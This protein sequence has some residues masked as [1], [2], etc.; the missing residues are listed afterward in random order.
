MT[1]SELL[2]ELKR[3]DVKL[4]AEGG[5]LRVDAPKG[6]LS[7]G[8]IASIRG[9]KARLLE[10]FP[11]HSDPE[12]TIPVRRGERREFPLSLSQHAFFMLAQL[13]PENRA[14][15]IH[16]VRRV[17]GPIDTQ[18][19]A[20]AVQDVVARHETL[21][22]RFELRDG[23]GVQIVEAEVHAP[24]PVVDLSSLPE[25]VRE[26]QA[27]AMAS[28]DRGPGFRIQSAPLF[29]IE[30]IR[31][32][33][34]SHVFVLSMHHIVSD[35]VSLDVFYGDLLQAYEQR[36]RGRSPEFAA[37]PVQY[38]DYSEWQRR[39]MEGPSLAGELEFWRAE[40]SGVPRL[41]DALA[42]VDAPAADR[43]SSIKTALPDDL[44]RRL[45]RF[46]ESHGA[47]LF[48]VL[49]SAFQYLLGRYAR[50]ADVPVIVPFSARTG[51]ETE[52][53]IGLFVNGLVV[54]TY[55]RARTTAAELVAA[56]RKKIADVLSH[57]ELSVES[58][59]GLFRLGGRP[60]PA[61]AR[62]SRIGFNYVV[63]G[64]RGPMQIGGLTVEPVE[65]D[66]T[67]SVFELM[68]T[69]TDSAGELQLRL[70]YK[71]DLFHEGLIEQF[72]GDLVSVLSG[73]ADAPDKILDEIHL[74]HGYEGAVPLPPRA[75]C[76]E[77]LNKGNHR[78]LG[79][80]IDLEYPAS[81]AILSESLAT[82]VAASPILRTR[83]VASPL[84][85]LD[86]EYACV[87]MVCDTALEEIEVH[88][89]LPEAILRETGKLYAER[90]WRHLI[91]RYPDGRRQYVFL[92]NEA[93]LGPRA[94]DAHRNAVVRGLQGSIDPGDSLEIVVDPAAAATEIAALSR[95]AGRAREPRLVSLHKDVDDL[96]AISAWCDANEITLSNFFQCVY[97]LLIQ[98][99]T[100]AD[101]PFSFWLSA[102]EVLEPR[103]FQP[104]AKDASIASGLRTALRRG[105]HIADLPANEID[106]FFEESSFPEIRTMASGRSVCVSL[107]SQ[108]DRASLSLYFD[109]AEFS[110]DLF[111]DR[112]ISVARQIA[113]P[114][115][116]WADLNLLAGEEAERIAAVNGSLRRWP[117]G[118]SIVDLFRE[119]VARTPG[120]VAVSCGDRSLN[121][122]EADALSD[123]LAVWL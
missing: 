89:E 7:P 97:G 99:Y 22:T 6:A 71:N 56:V 105:P 111:L 70:E 112:M 106:F 51:T 75:R 101:V 102:A 3:K 49:L 62:M 90:P 54:R 53:L 83:I 95:P 65:V 60:E 10:L 45:R 43:A 17:T 32:D 5:D 20:Q 81:V 77:L 104:P 44:V 68:L 108:G 91:C 78:V 55:L 63:A 15:N 48:A 114:L 52:R 9:N 50:S 119:Q 61:V 117:P 41:L 19:L 21:R 93:L 87:R 80:A 85:W 38:G 18:A 2:A 46:A 27:E 1:I 110:D 116:S 67:H 121:Y 58:L 109:A 14:Y 29:R 31:L 96:G 92:A 100:Q 25:N 120:E 57:R 122:R 113:G 12:P 4:H 72:T 36:S 24:L 13:E 76:L 39:R 33:A 79:Y 11:R 66:R 98:L 73:M 59:E 94:I 118:D 47:T 8:L 88:N 26:R 23:A 123:K 115:S 69:A 64:G 107:H 37:L 28:R 86:R 42:K 84:P 35:A 40:L 103:I 30:L 82:L 16:S 74:S 34:A